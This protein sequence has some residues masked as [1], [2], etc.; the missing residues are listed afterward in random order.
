VQGNIAAPSTTSSSKS[1]SI[2]ISIIIMELLYDCVDSLVHAIKIVAQSVAFL[3]GMHLVVI[4]HFLQFL[5]TDPIGAVRNQSSPRGGATATSTT[6]TTTTTTS[7]R[8]YHSFSSNRPSAVRSSRPSL[9]HLP[10]LEPRPYEDPEREAPF[11]LFGYL[12]FRFGNLGYKM[13]EEIVDL[14]DQIES[15]GGKTA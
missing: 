12:T 15:R 1:I 9:L 6:T 3:L 8:S 14:A 5:T 7:R 11:S 2:I 4:L 13:K 10:S